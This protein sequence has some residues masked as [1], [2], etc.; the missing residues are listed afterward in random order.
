MTK[1]EE[2]MRT[3]TGRLRHS[4]EERTEDLARIGADTE[5]VLGQA[6][7]FM[8]DVASDR[9]VNSERLFAFLADDRTERSRVSAE[10]RDRRRQELEACREKT[11]Q[12]LMEHRRATTEAVAAL[13]AR[14]QTARINLAN[15]LGHAGRAW[16]EFASSR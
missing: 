11:C 10:S 9:R 12:S 14:F 1:F 15:D 2:N 16:R 3:F 7:S 8:A 5:R 6:R 4:I 13:R